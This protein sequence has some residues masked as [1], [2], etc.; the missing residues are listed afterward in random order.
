MKAIFTATMAAVI[1][2]VVASTTTAKDYSAYR[3]ECSVIRDEVEPILSNAG[4][5]P[6][7]LYLLAAESHCQGNMDSHVVHQRN[8][9]KGGHL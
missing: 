7:Y 3:E 9:G 8:K 4:V 5:T 2:T 6:D 1:L